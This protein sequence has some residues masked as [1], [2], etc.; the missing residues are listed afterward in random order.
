[1]RGIVKLQCRHCL[2]A[3][4]GCQNS[5]FHYFRS[6]LYVMN[7]A[8]ARLWGI[9]SYIFSKWRAHYWCPIVFSWPTWQP[10]HDW[11]SLFHSTIYKSKTRRE[12]KLVSESNSVNTRLNSTVGKGASC[13]MSVFRKRRYELAY[14]IVFDELCDRRVIDPVF[15]FRSKYQPKGV[16]M[17]SIV[18]VFY[19]EPTSLILNTPSYSRG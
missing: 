10:C 11:Y 3:M 5:N 17:L 6:T 18:K 19:S 14:W 13:L 15:F 9:S 16:I 2:L 1:M 4:F 8:E 12:R 7:F